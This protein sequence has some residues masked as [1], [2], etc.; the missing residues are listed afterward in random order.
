MKIAH[1]PAINFSHDYLSRES[2]TRRI[3]HGNDDLLWKVQG[4][5]L[6]LECVGCFA[7]VVT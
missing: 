6:G 7:L 5:A 4:Y 1:F 3:S 2:I